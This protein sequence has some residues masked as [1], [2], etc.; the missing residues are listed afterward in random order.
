MLSA[1]LASRGRGVGGAAAV[2]LSMYIKFIISR[3]ANSQVISPHHTA[4]GFMW[5]LLIP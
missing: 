5:H 3:T 1:Y 4:G 2:N